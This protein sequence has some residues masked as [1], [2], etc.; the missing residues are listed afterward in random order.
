MLAPFNVS[1]YLAQAIKLQELFSF[2]NTIESIKVREEQYSGNLPNLMK[3]HTAV[4]LLLHFS[5]SS[6]PQLN[7]D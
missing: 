6:G 7:A 3:Q 5:Q 4:G 2:N 1:I